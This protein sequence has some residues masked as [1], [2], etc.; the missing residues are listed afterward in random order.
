MKNKFGFVVCVFAACDNGTTAGDR[1]TGTTWKMVDGDHV[2]DILTFSISGT[3]QQTD[4]GNV[5][6]SGSY[7][8]SSDMVILIFEQSSQGLIGWQAVGAL[9]DGGTALTITVP[10][11]PLANPGA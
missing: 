2:G 6:N 3:W 8:V 11:M 7:S 4:D 1:F 10:S 5:R 9:S